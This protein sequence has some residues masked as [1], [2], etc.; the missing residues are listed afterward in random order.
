MVDVLILSTYDTDGAGKFTLQL[1]NSLQE[2]GYSTRVVC[3]RSRSG[4]VNTYGLIDGYPMR[5]V[6]YRLTQEF[7]R[8]LFSVRPEY[9]FIHLH[10]LSDR[11]VLDSGVWP[12]KCRLIICTFLSGMMSPSA[13]LA[14]RERYRNPPVIF[15]GVDMNLYTGGCHYSRDCIAYQEDCSNCP[16]VPKSLRTKVNRDFKEKIDCFQRI[17]QHI[18]VASSNEHYQ[19]MS[20]SRIFE[21]S[22]IRHLLMAVDNCLYGKYE[23]TREDLKKTYGF[24]GRAILVRSSSEPRKGCD[25]FVEAIRRIE[26]EMPEILNTMTIVAIGDQYVSDQLRDLQLNIYSPGFISDKDELSKMYSAA[27][28]FLMTSHSDSGPVM[29]AQSLMSGTPVISTDVGLARDLVCPPLNG[30]IMKSPCASE[31][32]DLVVSFFDSSDEEIA[33]MRK[34]ARELALEQLG[35]AHYQAN[36]DKMVGE[37]LG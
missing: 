31:L 5:Q 21:K 24:T 9:A 13:F 7:E 16:A 28:V 35:E 26:K 36:L 23:A 25:L 10:G 3:V 33:I 8:R 14:V 29:L 20:R 12:N 27:D 18:V 11:S 34:N 4:D 1:S 32:K 2:L 6:T 37:M 30:N 19:Q 17:K 15:Y 22:D